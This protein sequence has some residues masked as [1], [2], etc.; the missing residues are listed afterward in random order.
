MYTIHLQV[1]SWPT[2]L[3]VVQ[4]CIA[5]VPNQKVAKLP[6][7]SSS[8]SCFFFFFYWLVQNCGILSQ[9]FLYKN[10]GILHWAVAPAH[11]FFT[12]SKSHKVVQTGHSTTMASLWCH[13]LHFYAWS[14]TITQVCWIRYTVCVHGDGELF[15]F[16]LATFTQCLNNCL[17]SDSS[18]HTPTEEACEDRLFAVLCELAD[19]VHL[20]LPKKVTQTRLNNIKKFSIQSRP[21]YL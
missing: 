3:L 1:F 4:E 9:R 21:T 2:K 20:L 17:V 18:A 14:V 12:T 11:W 5:N 6:K 16:V 15:G 13:F 8:S 7:S 10:S 19:F